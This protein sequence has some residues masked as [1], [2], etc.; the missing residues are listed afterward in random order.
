[1][2]RLQPTIVIVPRMPPSTWPGSWQAN[3]HGPGPEKVYV[4][5]AA[6]IG[7]PR[8]VPMDPDQWTAN[9]ATI[10]TMPRTPAAIHG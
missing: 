3:P 1:M 2:I 10:R 9:P 8:A 4:S 7:R 5:E 6:A